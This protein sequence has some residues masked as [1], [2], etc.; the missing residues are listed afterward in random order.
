MTNKEGMQQAIENLRLALGRCEQEG[1]HVEIIDYIDTPRVD[2]V[3]YG[4]KWDNSHHT[5]ILVPAN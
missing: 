1:L 5:L 4:V 3:I 2:V